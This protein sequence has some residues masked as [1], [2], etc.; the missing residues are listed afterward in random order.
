[1]MAD[2]IGV[3]HLM[4]V[5][6]RWVLILDRSGGS[7]KAQWTGYGWAGV[8]MAPDEVTHWRPLT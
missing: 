6:K 2:W 5:R 8:G 7:W 1:M 4:P 3:E